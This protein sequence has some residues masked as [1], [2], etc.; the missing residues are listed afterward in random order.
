MEQTSLKEVKRAKCS[1]MNQVFL[2][3]FLQQ[4]LLHAE[5]WIHKF[6]SSKTIHLT[7]ND[8]ADG[9]FVEVDL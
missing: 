5:N 9:R 3:V 4:P 1:M 2:R 6:T 8:A 7:A